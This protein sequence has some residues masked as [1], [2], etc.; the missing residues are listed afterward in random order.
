MILPDTCV[1]IEYF[2]GRE[3]AHSR[4]S[5]LL[6]RNEVLACELVFGELLQ[7]AK[8]K[9]EVEVLRAFWE[10]LPKATVDGALIA[11]GIES[12]KREF[13]AA[14]VGLVDAAILE[15]ARGLGAEI[16]TIDKKFLG[17]LPAQMRYSH[18]G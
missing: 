6:E 1:W 4:L 17:M 18:S 7:G 11:A 5:R 15:Y 13:L 9:R 2:R 10:N 16:W 14:G 8:G 3:P 12:A